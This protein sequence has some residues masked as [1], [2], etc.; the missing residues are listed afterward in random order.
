MMM[1]KLESLKHY[2][3]GI[4]LS[5]RSMN[6][7]IDVICPV[8]KSNKTKIVGTAMFGNRL[9]TTIHDCMFCWNRFSIYHHINNRQEFIKS[10][11][12]MS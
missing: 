1:I 10:V 6:Y 5:N 12:D 3:T 7:L 2:T 9:T 8:C 4:Y 11:E